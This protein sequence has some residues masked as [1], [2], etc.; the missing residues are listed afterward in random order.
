M[1]FA[2]PR[3]AGSAFVRLGVDCFIFDC[4]Q[5]PDHTTLRAIL[6]YVAPRLP[7]L[8]QLAPSSEE[9]EVAG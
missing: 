7:E 9:M 3:D 5:F 6:E 4:A 1:R 8:A 2:K